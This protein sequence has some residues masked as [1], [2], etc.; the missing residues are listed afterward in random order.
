MSNHHCYAGGLRFDFFGSKMNGMMNWY[1]I[2]WRA[3]QTYCGDIGLDF[4][5]T[6]PMLEIIPMP[7]I[8][9]SF[10]DTKLW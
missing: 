3:N 7:P 6:Q 4:W 8:V 9:S 10:N 1:E 5:G 2:A